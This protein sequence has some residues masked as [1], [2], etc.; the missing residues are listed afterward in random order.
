MFPVL[1]G[2]AELARR[3][4]V[5]DSAEGLVSRNARTLRT[6]LSI[7]LAPRRTTA[8]AISRSALV[9]AAALFLAGHW[10]RALS[11]EGPD[12]VPVM[13]P[14]DVALY[15]MEAALVALVDGVP[16]EEYAKNHPAEMMSVATAIYKAKDPAAEI[17]RRDEECL[18]EQ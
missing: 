9:L 17:E 16:L 1:E 10:G 12:E 13:G 8:I 5:G 6:G 3:A 7:T 18:Q 11:T 4:P 15:E 2:L 14:C